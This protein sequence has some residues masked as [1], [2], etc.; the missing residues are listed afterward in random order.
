M[1]STGRANPYPDSQIFHVGVPMSTAAAQLAADEGCTDDLFMLPVCLIL[2]LPEE[3]TPEG[4]RYGLCP[5]VI[6]YH[7]SNVEAFHADDVIVL[8]Q[9]DDQLVD[10]VKATPKRSGHTACF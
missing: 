10:K 5:I 8:D 9:L 6:S 2:Q 4:I 7:S 3:L 1:Y